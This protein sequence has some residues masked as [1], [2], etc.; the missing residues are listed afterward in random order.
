[1]TIE[2]M[3]SERKTLAIRVRPDGTVTVRAPLHMPDKEIAAAVEKHGGWIEKT[4]ARLRENAARF[5]A[6]TPEEIRALRAR[7]KDLIPQRV[8]YYSAVMGVQPAGVRI[9]GAKTR[10]GS[11]SPK[12]AL[13]FSY[14]LLRYPPEAVDYVVVHEL[15]H[16]R[17]HDH[18]PAFWAE[19]EKYMPDYK[20]RRALLR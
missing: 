4:A 12:N 2:V 1:M 16:I 5:P 7:A 18:S 6:L 11:C 15:A 8:A 13:S 19:V 3:R 9:T 14:L 17:H 20:A 10:F